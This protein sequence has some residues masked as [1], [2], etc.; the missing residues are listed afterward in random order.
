[1]DQAF[2]RY[3]M[4]TDLSKPTSD[5]TLNVFEHKNIF[6]ATAS[7]LPPWAMI[8]EEDFWNLEFEYGTPNLFNDLVKYLTGGLIDPH[9]YYK[10]EAQKIKYIERMSSLSPVGKQNTIAPV[11]YS[12]EDLNSV[13]FWNLVDP[14]LGNNDAIQNINMYEQYLSEKKQK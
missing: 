7:K 9:E 11:T 4:S 1:M 3:K 12:Q 2:K 5:I 13:K 14:N 6:T 8:N 10:K